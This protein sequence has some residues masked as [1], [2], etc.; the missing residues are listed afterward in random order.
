MVVSFVGVRLGRAAFWLRQLACSW[1]PKWP[2]ARSSCA[3]TTSTR[4]SDD[5][6]KLKCKTRERSGQTQQVIKKLAMTRL[7]ERNSSS[8]TQLASDDADS[9]GGFAGHW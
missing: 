8:A 7:S 6:L 9:D 3:G 5:G 1:Y 2:D 4:D